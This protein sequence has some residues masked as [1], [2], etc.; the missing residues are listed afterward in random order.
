[1]YGKNIT[2]Y[3]LKKGMTKKQLAEAAKVSTK[4]VSEYEAERRRPTMK[5]LRALSYALGIRTSDLLATQ[6][7]NLHIK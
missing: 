2:Y 7:N 5:T 4:T 3:R 1:M 6:T